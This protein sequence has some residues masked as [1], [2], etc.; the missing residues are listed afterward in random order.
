MRRIAVATSI[1]ALLLVLLA[2]SSL[3]DTSRFR[4][5]GCVDNPHWKPSIRTI[6]KGDRIVW[7]NAAS[8]QHTV[9]AYGRGWTKS[10]ALSPG[11]TT[12]KRFRKTGTYKFRCLT[13]GHSVLENGTCN[14]MCGKVRV[15][16]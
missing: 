5:V 14:G 3:G 1:G 7:K 13:Q 9:N 2:P 11:D 15:T 6:T 12:A 16:R 4:G 8:C 10:T